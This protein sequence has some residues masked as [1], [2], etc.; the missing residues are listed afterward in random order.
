MNFLALRFQHMPRSEPIIPS[1]STTTMWLY[2][3]AYVGLRFSC[4]GAHVPHR[5]TQC[6]TAYLV[7]IISLSFLSM[8]SKAGIGFAAKKGFCCSTSSSSTSSSSSRTSCSIVT[9]SS[10]MRAT[11]RVSFRTCTCVPTVRLSP[12]RKSNWRSLIDV[13]TVQLVVQCVDCMSILT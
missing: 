1:M 12:S 5:I 4:V 9:R 7:L 10:A 3:K 13:R 2:V 8:L 6:R 11:T